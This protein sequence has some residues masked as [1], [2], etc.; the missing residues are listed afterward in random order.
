MLTHR[1]L[2][3][4]ILLMNAPK[5]VQEVAG[6][7]PQAVH[8]NDR[9]LTEAIAVII[10]RP[11]FPTMRNG[12]MSA[13]DVVIALPFIC[14][15]GGRSGGLSMNMLVE[16]LAIGLLTH[17]QSALSRLPPDGVHNGRPVGFI[18]A[19]PSSFVRSSTWW[20]GWIG[21]L[22]AFF[23]PRSGT[24]HR[25]LSAYQPT[26][27]RSTAHKPWLESFA[28]GNE[29]WCNSVASLQPTKHCFHPYRCHAA[30]ARLSGVT[31]HGQPIPSHYRDC[32]PDHIADSDNPSTLVWR[33]ETLRLDPGGLHT[34]DTQSP[35]GE[36]A[37]QS[38]GCFRPHSTGR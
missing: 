5:W 12:A 4:Q 9:H 33:N 22:V 38:T 35:D 23:P 17:S 20:I 27:D 28:G 10:G 24:S 13:V 6:G 8:R 26:A 37:V 3:F 11:F 19:V 2:V 25:F 18:R 31:I 21:V 36:K 1:Q 29:P 32:T 14:I 7:G 16:R 15:A 30:G 34:E